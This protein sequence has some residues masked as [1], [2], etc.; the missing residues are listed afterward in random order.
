MDGGM[1]AAARSARRCGREGAPRT[2]EE[3]RRNGERSSYVLTAPFFEAFGEGADFVTRLH[4]LR[5]E[6]SSPGV[7]GPHLSLGVARCGRRWGTS[8]TQDW[9]S[10][11]SPVLRVNGPDSSPTNHSIAD[12][13]RTGLLAST[14]SI[15]WGADAWPRR[16]ICQRTYPLQS[17]ACLMSSMHVGVS[18]EALLAKGKGSGSGIAASRQR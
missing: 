8:R 5:G 11:A 12:S 15:L 10:D 9:R 1:L 6:G 16:T 14:Q 2:Y 4:A 18:P 17:T 13:R 7:V 3:V